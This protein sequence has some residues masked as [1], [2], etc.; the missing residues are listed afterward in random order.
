[1]V[2]DVQVHVVLHVVERGLDRDRICQIVGQLHVMAAGF[3]ERLYIIT[4]Y[5]IDVII[6]QGIFCQLSCLCS[7]QLMTAKIV[8][9]SKLTFLMV[10]F[11]IHRSITLPRSECGSDVSA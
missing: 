6:I 9:K 11:T 4:L 1:M 2:E 10:P 5:S 8:G 7:F 3:S